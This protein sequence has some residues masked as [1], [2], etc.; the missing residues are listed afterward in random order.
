M[1]SS[2]NF[3]QPNITD[4][5][6]VGRDAQRHLRQ[7]TAILGWTH[8]FSADT[9]LHTS[10]YT[11]SS[12]DHVLPTTDPITPLSDASRS[13][14]ALGVKSDLSHSWRSHFFKAGVG[15]CQLREGESVFFAPPRRPDTFPALQ[16]WGKSRAD[17]VYFQQH[18][19]PLLNPTVVAELSSGHT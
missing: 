14:F 6:A 2:A 12:S 7:Y 5:Q 8:T 13:G 1:G 19:S 11:R 10:L 16:G 15:L 17:R 4:D 18:F 3:Q 9:L